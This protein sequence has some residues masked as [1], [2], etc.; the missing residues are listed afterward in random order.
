M[1]GRATAEWW[2]VILVMVWG[3][4]PG[5]AGR[6]PQESRDRITPVVDGGVGLAAVGAARARDVRPAPPANFNA[7]RR[8]NTLMVL[9]L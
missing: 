9:S 6:A 1:S 3:F 8:L 4:P 2:M 7:W 5:R